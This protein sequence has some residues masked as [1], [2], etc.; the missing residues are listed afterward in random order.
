MGVNEVTP[1]G[2]R[3]AGLRLF[4]QR[5]YAAAAEQLRAAT[6]AYAADSAARCETLNDLGV[7]YRLQRN[8]SAAIAALEDA[9]AGFARLGDGAGQG[10]ALANLGDVYAGIKQQEQAA[11]NYS[12]ASALLARAGDRERQSRVLWALSLH[13]VRRGR[14]LSAMTLMEQSLSLRPRLGVGG[15]LLRALLRLALGMWSG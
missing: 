5:Q 15:W 6:A 11:I 4:R 3:A 8:G 13:H 7:V 1:D 14:W 12:E 2:L 10:V 9:A